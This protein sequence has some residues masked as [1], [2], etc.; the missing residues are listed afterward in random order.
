MELLGHIFETT[1]QNCDS[2]IAEQHENLDPVKI[3]EGNI[4][5]NDCTTYSKVFDNNLFRVVLMPDKTLMIEFVKDQDA[6]G[7]AIWS[8]VINATITKHMYRF[9]VIRQLEL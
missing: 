8:K 7:K 5:W 6:L 9:L 3:W 2:H 4:K 1:H